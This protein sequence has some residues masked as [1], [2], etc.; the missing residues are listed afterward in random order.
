VILLPLPIG[1]SMVWIFW[2]AFWISVGG[3]VGEGCVYS[4]ALGDAGTMES[5]D[6]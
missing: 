6:A 2:D 1:Y 5:S 3:F 4:G